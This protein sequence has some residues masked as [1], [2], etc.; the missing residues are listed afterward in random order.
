MN[1]HVLIILNEPDIC[2]EI[3][4]A[5]SEA[6][7]LVDV[8]FSVSE[9]VDLFLHCDYSLI[10]IDTNTDTKEIVKLLRGITSVP[11]L[12]LCEPTA[13]KE[14]CDM[15]M[16]G[17][18]ACLTKPIDL[19]ECTAQVKSLLNLY[20]A[21][22]EK[23]AIRTI[24]YGTDFVIYPEYRTVFLH[25]KTIELSRRE[26]DLLFFLASHDKQVFSRQQLYEQVWGYDLYSSVDDVVRACIK[27]IRQ[28]LGPTGQDY[29]QTV[30][31]V[32]YRFAANP[33][34]YQQL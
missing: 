23:R 29:V 22:I 27:H 26:F 3:Q 17:A 30:R 16:A 19:Q 14:R 24:A 13:P 10:L 32:G 33:S 5:L 4:T 20:F 9:A 15:L 1:S 18:S 8:A 21:T 6:T 25:G 31:G 2:V 28:K 7:M 12:A 34:I 11:I